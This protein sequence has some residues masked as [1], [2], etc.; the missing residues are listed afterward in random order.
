LSPKL[1]SWTVQASPGPWVGPFH[2]TSRRLRTVELAALQTFPQDYCFVGKRRDR[3][4][5]IGNAVPALLAQRMIEPLIS[6]FSEPASSAC[7]GI[8]AK[9]VGR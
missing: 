1:P 6:A 8:R 7:S 9:A 4:K 3:V 2:W 5:Q